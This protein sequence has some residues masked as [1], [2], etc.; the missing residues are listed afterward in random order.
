MTIKMHNKQRSSTLEP[1][2][3][4]KEDIDS[5]TNNH[6]IKLYNETIGAS[7]EQRAKERKN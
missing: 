4:N 2:N 5:C 7:V 1:N 3:K 6:E